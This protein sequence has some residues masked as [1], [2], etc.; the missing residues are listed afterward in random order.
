MRA[1]VNLA[2]NK[3]LRVCFADIASF[4]PAWDPLQILFDLLR[5]FCLPILRALSGM[6]SCAILFDL[7]SRIL[8]PLSVASPPISTIL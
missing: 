3:F 2:L 6:G 1:D 4:F 8:L 7:L 5:F